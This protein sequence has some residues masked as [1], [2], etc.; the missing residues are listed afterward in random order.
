M[1]KSYAAIWCF[2]LSAT[3][4]LSGCKDKTKPL[5][6]RIAKAWTAETVNQDNTTVYTRGASSNIVPGYSGYKLTLS[7]E[8]G[9]N[10]A[11]MVE[12][13]NDSFVGT[14]ELDGDTKL[15][16][17][18]LVPQPTGTGGTIQFTI[19][20][21]DDSK[22]VITRLDASKKTGDTINKYTLTNP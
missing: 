15:I 5:S 7:V 19:N 14:W 8:S 17:K 10:K 16:L 11:T 12:F 1:K 20:S 2:V 13:N 18:N 22:L 6:E 3:L 4:I 9:V 21:I